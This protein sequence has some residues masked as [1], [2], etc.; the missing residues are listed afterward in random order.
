MQFGAYGASNKTF[1]AS[2][3]DYTIEIGGD[4]ILNPTGNVGIGTDDPA[5]K[6]HIETPTA[7]GW[8]LRLDSTGLSNES[9]F[10]RDANDN[11]EAVLRSG[12]GALSYIKN[13]GG[14]G[15]ANLFFYVQ[16]SDRLNINSS[17]NIG[18]GTNTQ[19]SRLA[20]NG[21]ITESTDGGTTYHNVVTA[22]DIGTDPNQVPLN[23]FLGQL[24]FMDSIGDVPTASTP[25]QDN[26][27]INFEYVS[28]T[29]IKIRMRGTD[30][31]VRSVTLT[32]S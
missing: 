25:P 10:Y 12:A 21:S 6:L 3:I 9:G 27:A 11:Y 28:N 7:Q 26:L 1:G 31:V 8:Q 5:A 19:G 4:L 15:A 30:G 23:Q 16:G 24:A 14:A 20:V 2:T 18:I 29:S 17:G 13:S 32:L 22:Q